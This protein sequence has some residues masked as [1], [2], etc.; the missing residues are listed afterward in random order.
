MFRFS[1]RDWFWLTLVVAILSA[2]FTR[3]QYLTTHPKRWHIIHLGNSQSM[4]DS[5]VNSPGPSRLPPAQS[6]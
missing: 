3:E 5:A 2:W 1:V 4:D 6:N